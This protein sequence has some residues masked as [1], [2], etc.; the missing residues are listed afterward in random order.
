M[1]TIVF[2][3]MLNGR[4]ITQVSYKWCPAFPIDF[5]EIL[6]KIISKR[7]SL[8]GKHIELFETN[9]VVR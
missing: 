6:R 1:K 5:E 9:C 2:D 4:F 7:P 3:V 8:K